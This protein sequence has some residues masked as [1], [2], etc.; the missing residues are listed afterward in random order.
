MAT[1]QQSPKVTE[2]TG[3][4]RDALEAS[5]FIVAA[6][7]GVSLDKDRNKRTAVVMDEGLQDK[8]I[9]KLLTEI[10]FAVVVQPLVMATTR[11]QDGP[12]WLIDCEIMVKVMVNPERNAS[13]DGGA[14]V[15]IYSA[16]VAV[17]EALCRKARHPGGENFKLQRDA[18]G[19]SQ[20]DAGLWVYNLMFTKEAVL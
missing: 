9:Q 15:N 16:A 2:L 3:L 5:A 17:I 14:Q 1:S 4:V 18:F 6:S 8:R 19:L 10:G 13:D 20:F 7:E 12:A 11:D